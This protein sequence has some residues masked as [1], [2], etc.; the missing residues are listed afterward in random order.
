MS[1]LVSDTQL[2]TGHGW[3]AIVLP[4]TIYLH[5]DPDG[6]PLPGAVDT[7]LGVS[8]RPYWTVEWSHQDEFGWD[9]Y[10]LALATAPALLVVV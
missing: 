2:V 10:L 6:D 8:R 4:E 3:A 5:V 1:A 7:L 9:V